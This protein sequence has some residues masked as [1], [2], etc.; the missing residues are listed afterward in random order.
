MGDI[1][2]IGAAVWGVLMA[3][4]PIL[5]IRR[6]TLRRSSVDVSIGNLAVLQIGFCLW[7][8]YGIS[9]GNPVIVVPNAM[10]AA[11]GVATIGFSWRY[12]TARK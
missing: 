3:L 8:A 1:L 2:G 7:L 10:A 11:V 9:L 4:S 5:Q 12:R 6:I